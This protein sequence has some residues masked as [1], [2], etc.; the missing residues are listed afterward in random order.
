M[1]YQ[2]RSGPRHSAHPE[3]LICRS[4]SDTA[5]E[6]LVNWGATHFREE[7]VSRQLDAEELNFRFCP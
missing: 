4:V 5:L 6:H 1:L 7:R 3:S 2:K